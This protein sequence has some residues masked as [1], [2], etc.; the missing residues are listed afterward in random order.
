M[1]RNS[2]TR[3]RK[4]RTPNGPRLTVRAGLGEA[5]RKYVSSARH[6]ADGWTTRTSTYCDGT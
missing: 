5:G 4:N 6:T 2:K 1:A 3:T